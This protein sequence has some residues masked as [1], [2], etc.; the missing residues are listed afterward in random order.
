[1][2]LCDRTQELRTAFDSDYVGHYPDKK[3]RAGHMERTANTARRADR[4]RSKEDDH[5]KHST[6]VSFRPVQNWAQNW[7]RTANFSSQ[8]Y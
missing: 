7:S 3:S 4:M 5:R 2:K 1:M 6:Y 8:E